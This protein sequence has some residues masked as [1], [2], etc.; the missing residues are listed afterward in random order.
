[1]KVSIHLRSERKKIDEAYG[2]LE[3]RRCDNIS[4][5]EKENL[6]RKCSQVGSRTCAPEISSHKIKVKGQGLQKAYV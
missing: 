6:L 5:S 4:E 2:E 3:V 1:M